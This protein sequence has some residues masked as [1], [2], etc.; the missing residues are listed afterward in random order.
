MAYVALYRKFRPQKFEDMVG[1][2]HITKTL[3]NQLINSRVALAKIFAVVV[4]PLPRPP[5]NKYA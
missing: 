5:L 3:K 1:Q 2:E 4:L